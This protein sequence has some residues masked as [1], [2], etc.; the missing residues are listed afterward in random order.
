MLLER[1]I[2][3]IRPRV[4][5]GER[6]KTTD[7]I[8]LQTK[9]D[10]SSPSFCQRQAFMKLRKT[11][12]WVHIHGLSLEYWQSKAIFSIVCG[13]GT[14]LSLDDHT[15]NK[16]RGFLARVLVDVDLLF[17]LPNQIL[18]ERSRFAFIDDMECEK[19]PLIC[20]NYKMIGHDLS[21]CR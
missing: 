11:Q 13:I 7:T 17:V 4:F 19:L 16:S 15:K 18:V 3:K 9:H 5:F 10:S 1:K 6:K 2:G 8:H 14:P 21:N 20:S 12:C